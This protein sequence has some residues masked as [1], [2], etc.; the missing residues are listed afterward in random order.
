M[1]YIYNIAGN[2]ICAR[3]VYVPGNE[4]FKCVTIVK[5]SRYNYF[6]GY[7]LHTIL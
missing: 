2:W 1:K 6:Y 4:N 5:Y 7:I 3:Y